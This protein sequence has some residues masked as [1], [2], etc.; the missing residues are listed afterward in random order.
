MNSSEIKILLVDDEPDILHFLKYNLEKED[1]W[2]YT[3]NNGNDGLKM[4]LKV[5]PD[6]IV[7]DIM[8]PEKNGIET[9]VALRNFP[10][11]KNTPIAFLTALNEQ[12]SEKICMQAGANDY[13]TKPIRPKLFINRILLLLHKKEPLKPSKYLF[14]NLEVDC[15]KYTV[16]VNKKPLTLPLKEFE[17]LCLLISKPGK[18]YRREE[19]KALVWKNTQ[20]NDDRIVD[21]HIYNLRE[22]IGEQYI[23]TVKGIGYSL[24][25]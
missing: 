7:L 21:A 10:N 14:E 16:I 8:M 12:E 17:L 24:A 20:L 5:Q 11:F 2:V 25:Y 23:K 13:I 4:A 1:F 9:C 3:A 6:L 15:E 19:I 18:I 22:K